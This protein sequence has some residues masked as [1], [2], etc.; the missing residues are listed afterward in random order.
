MSV[1][2][3]CGH[4]EALPGSPFLFFFS[5]IFCLFIYFLIS[6]PFYTPQCIHVNP[7]LPIHHTTTPNPCRFPPLGVHT[8]VLYF[9][10]SISALQTGSSVPFSRFYIYALIY[11]ICFSLSDI[12]HSLWQSLDPST[13]LQ[14]TKFHSFLWLSNIPLNICTTSSVSIR[15][16]MDI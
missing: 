3:V 10:V 8:F 12:L 7:N 14:M 6:H 13:P 4:C 11:D 9:C 1:C 5:F 16:S 15:L 2:G